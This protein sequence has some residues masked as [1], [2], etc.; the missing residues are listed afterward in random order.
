MHKVPLIKHGWRTVRAEIELLPN[1]LKWVDLSNVQ[2][3]HSQNTQKL[4]SLCALIRKISQSDMVED[5]MK[6]TCESL[7]KLHKSKPRYAQQYLSASCFG[8]FETITQIQAPA[9]QAPTTL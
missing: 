3:S 8:T 9:T 4:G 7:A 5:H 6:L 1:S 2:K